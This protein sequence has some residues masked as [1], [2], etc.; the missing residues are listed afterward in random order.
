M[1]AIRILEEHVA[2]QIAAGEVVERPASIVK[3]LL[4]NAIDAGAT[5]ITL[6]IRDGGI[7]YIRL[8]DNGGG[9]ASEDVPRAFL[10]HATSKIRTVQ[11]LD[12]VST[13][14]FR[15][16]A[17]ASIASV[18]QVEMTTR[19]PGA[20]AGTRIV[21]R[22]GE[23]L[24]LE[25]A[26]C[27]DG[28]TIVVNNL[29]FNTP[30]RLQ[31]LKKA[32]VEAN[33]VADTVQRAI[34]AHPSIAFRFLNN[35]KMQ[36]RAPGDGKL[37]S[38]VYAVYGRE[39][40]EGLLDIECTSGLL[41][42]HGVIGKPEISRFNRTSQTIIVNGR[43][44]RHYPVSSAIEAAYE[45]RLM[46]NRFPFFVL[47]LELPPREVN[48]NI[49]PNKMEVR[50]L[51]EALVRDTV[52]AAAEAAL[53]NTSLFSQNV[54]MQIPP[55]STPK[56]GVSARA[57]P[58]KAEIAREP[59]IK[60]ERQGEK[61]MPVSPGVRPRSDMAVSMPIHTKAAAE[62]AF[63]YK[64]PIRTE[65][66]PASAISSKLP[67]EVAS[68]GAPQVRPYMPFVGD[69][70]SK[71][72]TVQ[73]SGL[74]PASVP[75]IS[76]YRLIGQLFSTYLLVEYKEKLLLIDQH[77]AHERLLYERLVTMLAEGQALSQ[78]LLVP[79]V[80]RMTETEKSVLDEHLNAFLE[81]GYVITPLGKTSYQIEAVPFF[82]GEPQISDFFYEALERIAAQGTADDIELRRETL[83][84]LSCKHAIKAGDTLTEKEM[85]ALL[86]MIEREAI[87]LT[88]PHG[89]P[90]VVSLTKRELEKQFK[91][92]V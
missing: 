71:P 11:D 22:G 46:T 19:C 38:A 45:T 12:N 26:G 29:F 52:R 23:V 15:G 85:E 77:A 36:Y 66:T 65:K 24:S 78:T 9:I 10:S 30:V 4:E 31:F 68:T 90:I 91:R 39:T 53:R 58:V 41:K 88:C 69:V 44:V 67:K 47:H 20:L 33:Y 57:L 92:I 27:P 42:V 3:E 76:A 14:G 13:M 50:F 56:D 63:G 83:M 25:E 74:L 81:L 48:V 40:A 73:E 55:A 75:E 5:A 79:H 62:P 82:L 35:G 2:N 6:E 18:A 7:S 43:P 51:N 49:H 37:H 1:P 54:E 21:L 8:S 16:E 84:Q 32:S 59:F 28:T 64:M 87:P 17:L 70:P 89:R 60:Q 61:T 80:L 34:L 86:V 72:L